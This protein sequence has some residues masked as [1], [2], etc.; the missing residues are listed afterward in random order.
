[1]TTHNNESDTTQGGREDSESGWEEFDRLMK[2]LKEAAEEGRRRM[3]KLEVLEE[4][5]QLEERRKRFG[6]FRR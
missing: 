1:M 3:I 6:L 2:E 5:E 4:L